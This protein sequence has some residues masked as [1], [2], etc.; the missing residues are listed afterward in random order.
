MKSIF[1]DKGSWYKGVLHLHSQKSDGALTI[2]EICN[3]YKRRG[4]D[5]IAITDHDVVTD[6]QSLADDKFLLISGIE[7][8]RGKTLTGKNIH[9]VALNVPSSFM[10]PDS[11]GAQ[12]AINLV[13]RKG[14]EVI[15]AHPYWSDLTSHDL[16]TFSGYLGIEIFNTITHR[17]FGRGLS[18]VHWDEL[19]NAGRN[20]RGFAVDDAH[21]LPEYFGGFENDATGGYIMV[22]AQNLKVDGIMDAIKKGSFYSSSGP[23]FLGFSLT[24]GIFYVKCSGVQSIS[25]I[26]SP[27]RRS[28]RIEKQGGELTESEFKPSGDIEYVRVECQDED[29]NYAWLNP[30][31]LES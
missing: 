22:K 7:M 1:K 8:S 21:F 2:E 19:L 5:F 20:V 25:F 17:G 24:N 16:L 30:Y 12:E 31:F 29:G 27:G 28:R 23:R 10:L 9:L 18:C 4:Y 26:C 6:S 3:F 11:Y 15:V 13:H 14:G